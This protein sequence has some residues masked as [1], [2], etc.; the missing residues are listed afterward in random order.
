MNQTV[1]FPA[2][3]GVVV[4]L[5]HEIRV[6]LAR[7]VH[8]LH[9]DAVLRHRDLFDEHIVAHIVAV[10][11][12]IHHPRVG[13]PRDP[14]ELVLEPERDVVAQKGLVA[15]VRDQDPVAVLPFAEAAELDLLVEA[16]GEGLLVP[17]HR[18]VAAALDLPG[19][20]RNGV[21][22]R[23]IFGGEGES[24][25][26][27][28]GKDGLAVFRVDV[29]GGSRVVGLLEKGVEG[30]VFVVGFGAVDD[31]LFPVAPLHEGKSRRGDRLDRRGLFPLSQSL[32]RHAGQ[33]ASFEG[34]D[35]EIHDDLVVGDRGLRLR[36]FKRFLFFRLRSGGGWGGT[37]GGIQQ[38]GGAQRDKG[39]RPFDPHE[40][41]SGIIS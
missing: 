30:G 33:T 35:R 7:V 12:E 24:Y 28:I 36:R 41:T 37:G 1:P 10:E 3:V 32:R 34:R 5:H 22:A 26:L 21:A 14:V 39:K 38:N 19:R 17:A 18:S 6:D 9:I 2:L 16:H 25:R 27:H 8:G 23:E 13:P 15:V 11:V 31:V 29:E 40:R 4:E 20:P